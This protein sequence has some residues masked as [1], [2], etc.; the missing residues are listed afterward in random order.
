M[1]L[2]VEIPIEINV[3]LTQVKI[4]KGMPKYDNCRKYL[5]DRGIEIP[6]DAPLYSDVDK[7]SSIDL[8]KVKE[9]NNTWLTTT[10]K[11]RYICK[12]NMVLKLLVTRFL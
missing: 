2:K 7:E 10:E 9:M 4:G 12:T 3:K 8:M 6:E 5:R 11:A 1:A